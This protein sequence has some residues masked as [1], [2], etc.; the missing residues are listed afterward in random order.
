MKAYF[1]VSAAVSALLAAAAY[2]TLSDYWTYVVPLLLCIPVLVY[3]K[4]EAKEN[5]FSKPNVFLNEAPAV[6]SLMASVISSGGSFDSAVRF[7]AEKGPEN[8]RKLFVSMVLDVDSRKKSDLREVYYETVSAFPAALSV[9]RRA[10]FMVVSASD[11]SDVSERARILKEATDIALEGLKHSGE[12]YSSKLQAPCMV[13]F[14]LGIMVPMILLSVVP[15]L[16]IGDSVGLSFGIPDE[17]L[18]LIILVVVPAIVCGVMFTMK[19]KNPMMEL[20]GN[21]SGLYKGLAIL[22]V[23]PV[24]IAVSQYIEDIKLAITVSVIVASLITASLVYQDVQKEKTR[25]KIETHLKDMLYE[26]G[27]RLITGENFETAL[28]DSLI[29]RKECRDLAEAVSRE[30]VMCRGDTEAAV[31]MCISP[32]SEKMADFICSICRA[33]AKDIRDAGRLAVAL[34]HQLQDQD[35]VRKEMNNKLRSMTDMMTGTAAVF[36]P[37]I[38]GLSVTMMGPIA[39]I[40]GNVNVDGTFTLIAVYLVELAILM[41]CFA[42]VLSGRFR[43]T[44][45]IYKISV[46]LPVSMIVLFACTCFSF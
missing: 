36:A 25:Q 16:K 17:V 39:S 34:A 10:L 40:S 46:V 31:R 41:S 18:E 23:I 28:Y 32:Y 30:F 42:S 1:P 24:F 19:G 3:M 5:V 38:L 13:V 14:G 15:M 6:I 33:S 7:V 9:F 4:T 45:V 21:Y 27:N 37:L 43:A 26:L 29:V 20:T 12:E 22:T 44:E 11:S 2:F 35:S 8:S